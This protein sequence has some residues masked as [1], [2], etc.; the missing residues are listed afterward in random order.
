[1]AGFRHYT[2]NRLEKLAEL[3]ADY[4]YS[5]ASTVLTP[6]TVIV[7]SKGME[8]R[9][10]MEIAR[11]RGICANIR[12]PFPNA[13]LHELFGLLSTEHA[14]APPYDPEVMVW[15][16]MSILPGFMPHPEFA[17]LRRYLHDDIRGLKSYQLSC[18]LA[19]LFDQYLI[20]RPE[21]ILAWEKGE[22][23]RD[24]ET[25]QAQLWRRLRREDASLHPAHI[26]RILLEKLQS[27]PVAKLPLPGRIFVFG[28]SRL[29]RFHFDILFALSKHVEVCLFSLN[30]CREF[31]TDI[32]SERET[33]RIVASIMESTLGKNISAV[34]LHLEAGNSL[35]AS[36]GMQGRDFFRR[37]GELSGEE[38]E[39]FFDTGETTLL[40]S[41]QADILNL[42]QRNT[43]GLP[44][45]RIDDDDDSLQFHSCHSPLRELEEL[46]NVILSLF[47]ADRELQPQDILVMT[48]DIERYAPLIQ[49][50]FDTPA[51]KDREN[52]RIPYTI[53]DRSLGRENTVLT[54]F[55]EL[56]ELAESRFETPSVLALLERHA[57]KKKFDMAPD[58]LERIRRWV[59]DAGIR[60]GID[61][62]FRQMAGL[63]AMPENT[64]K[65]GLARLFLGYAMPE[66]DE[67]L[68]E[69]I[70]PYN[71]MEG[72]EVRTLGVFAEYLAGLFEASQMLKK[73]K[74][75]GEWS[76]VL[77]SLLERFFA[78][79]EETQIQLQS[80]RKL[81]RLLRQLNEHSGF[82]A[83]VNLDVVKQF[84]KRHARQ[85]GF[86]SG[87]LSGGV[88]FCAMLPMRS[89]PF[90]VICLLG[91]NHD[92]YPRHSQTPG[93]DL[94]AKNPRPGDHSQRHDDRYLFLETLLSARQKLIISY[95]G[96][97]I[98]D[99]T[100][101]PP[102][103]LVSELLDYVEQGFALPAGNIRDRLVTRHHLQAFH[104]EYFLPQTGQFS[105]SEENLRAALSMRENRR[106]PS[107]LGGG[108]IE[109]AADRE[110]L[111][112]N[113]LVDFFINPCR[114]FMTR[115]LAATIAQGEHI[116]RDQE[117][118]EIEGLD[119]YIIKQRL[120][121]EALADCDLKSLFPL[122]RAMG[123]LP[124][125]NVGRSVYASLLKDAEAFA[126]RIKPYLQG[127]LSDAIAID[128]DIGGARLKG[129][130]DK[131]YAGG[132]CHFRHTGLKARD[133]LRLWIHHL[134]L[135]AAGRHTGE[136]RL[137][138]DNE[139]LVYRPVAD[140]QAILTQLLSV[141]R[142]GLCA[143]PPFFPKTSF[144]F[145]DRIIKGKSEKQALSAAW[146]AWEG[147]DF[148]R[149]ESADLYFSR[150]FLDR[151]PLNAEF[152]RVSLLVYEPLLKACD[153][154]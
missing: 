83:S 150:C 134:V 41:L 140:A 148:N 36:M 107:F 95:C 25:W 24:E 101:L 56:I 51:T 71:D 75:P 38:H 21:M 122:F 137:I 145:A 49:A 108:F 92:D 13:F 94:M 91:M 55:M 63:P 40:E 114:F 149:G 80:V 47:E 16:I 14:A 85:P 22:S 32:R 11:R 139:M 23:G 146:S 4:L 93:F 31:W 48:P 54:A 2:G 15:R 26:R 68:F 82:S 9:L 154:A 8:R 112:I 131:V 81:I 61:A 57:V 136:S 99:N 46:H 74:T 96:Q 113:D 87:F 151:D 19:D 147:S 62:E 88:T 86:G 3:L 52:M 65:A 30:P 115:R 89:I 127:G 43:E 130:I 27:R 124:H 6:E 118:F 109:P 84:I 144:A 78:G 105:Y 119:R 29:P 116:D 58:D 39:Y 42:R 129:R 34:E 69:G 104:P 141:C 67:L 110:T 64:W 135:L 106:A 7:Q 45:K 142:Q 102:S 143:P 128:M 17:E 12:F 132:L 126:A 100:P 111:E 152:V 18:R 121:E 72:I 133:H 35:L 1:M 60:W 37:L 77:T 66:R 153:R 73:P 20:F 97:S 125:G 90:K 50:V 5:P 44:T 120:V 59:Q 28:I 138:G 117:A 123:R 33:N 79:D 10:A 103:V 53:A 76:S 98:D 70:L